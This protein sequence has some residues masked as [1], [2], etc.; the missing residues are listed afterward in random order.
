[1]T[2]LDITRNHEGFIHG[3]LCFQPIIC[4]TVLAGFHCHKACAF[5][6][7]TIPA[8]KTVARTQTTIPVLWSHSY[9]GHLQ[10]TAV[11]CTNLPVFE[12]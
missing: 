9:W 11:K 12:Q 2:S 8:R 7:L 1:M 5:C 3:E 4:N 10:K 6:K